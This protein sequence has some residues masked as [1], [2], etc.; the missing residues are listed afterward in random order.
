MLTMNGNGA[1]VLKQK[2]SAKKGNT[3]MS[4]TEETRGT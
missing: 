1:D 2:F 3:V 4:A